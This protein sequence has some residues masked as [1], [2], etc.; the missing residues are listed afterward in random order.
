ME[1]KLEEEV[2][3]DEEAIGSNYYHIKS[4]Q[5]T[6]EEEEDIKICKGFLV[7]LYTKMGIFI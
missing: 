1:K 2:I 6:Q 4:W 7:L 3:L 5:K